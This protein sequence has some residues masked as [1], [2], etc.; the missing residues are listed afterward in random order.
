MQ[1][2]IF[3][4][5]KSS[6]KSIELLSHEYLKMISKFAKIEEIKIFN[7]QIAAAQ[8]IGEVEARASYT[9]AYEP[10]LK[11]FNVA[12]DVNGALVDSFEFS[13]FFDDEVSINFFIGGAFG[14]EEAFLK[15][16]QRIIS[17]SRLTYAHKIAKVVL[18]EQIYRGLCIKS[19]HPYHK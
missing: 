5:E 9:K 11:G 10:Y 7:K 19:N 15:K 13:H 14:F 6:D 8:S 16:T 12:L 18:C 4:I 2:K 17:L 1:I 3:T